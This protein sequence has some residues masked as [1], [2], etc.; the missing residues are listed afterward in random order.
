[1]LITTTSDGITA[2]ISPHG[3]IDRDTLPA[4]LAAAGELPRSVTG[5]T[6]DLRAAR[7]M[8]VAGLHLLIHQR[9]ACEER[10]RTVAVTGLQQQPLHLLQL[11]HD[12]FPAGH[13]NE[14]LPPGLPAA[15]TEPVLT[16]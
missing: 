16:R 2:V 10:G 4:L 12:L 5:V 11:A 7:V 9:L 15:A 14:F 6:W 13:W 1:M 8:D 3:E